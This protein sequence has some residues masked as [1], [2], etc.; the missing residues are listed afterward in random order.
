M[1]TSSAFTNPSNIT[2]CEILV[3]AGGGGGGGSAGP[4]QDG[5]A[6]V[7]PVA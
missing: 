5:V 6:V 3:V 1:F 2:D 4:S 7:V